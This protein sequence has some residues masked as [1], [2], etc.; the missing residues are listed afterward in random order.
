MLNPEQPRSTQKIK[1]G[2]ILMR[3]YL[4]AMRQEDIKL[5]LECETGQLW[6]AQEVNAV[7]DAMEEFGRI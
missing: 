7:L 1:R 6:T 2:V 3:G 4:R 5:Y